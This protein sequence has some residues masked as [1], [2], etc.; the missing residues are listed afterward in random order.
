[1]NMYLSSCTCPS[2]N[3]QVNLSLEYCTNKWDFQSVEISIREQ[4]VGLLDSVSATMLFFPL[5]YS[6]SKS[7]AWNFVTHFCRCSLRS[8]FSR[9]YF[10]LLWSVLTT[11][12]F[13]TKYYLNLVKGCIIASISLSY[14]EYN[15]SGCLSFLLS[16]T[17][18]F[19][20]A[21]TLI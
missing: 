10:K 15:L 13:P 2:N 5:T 21:S 12:L 14:I 16:N 18:G 19:P 6:M 7:K 20:P 8:F 11:H 17:M 9:K 3:S 1:M 4:V